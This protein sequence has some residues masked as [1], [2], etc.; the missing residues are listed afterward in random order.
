MY[1]IQSLNISL[2][3]FLIFVSHLITVQF[4]TNKKEEMLFDLSIYRQTTKRLVYC[5]L[6]MYGLIDWHSRLF[7]TK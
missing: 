7:I 3:L 5:T 6:T 4:L 1:Y 2:L